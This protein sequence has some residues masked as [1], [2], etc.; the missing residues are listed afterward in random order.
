MDEEDLVASWEN[1][2]NLVQMESQEKLD[3]KEFREHP[4]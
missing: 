3:H 1:L 2:E 4:E